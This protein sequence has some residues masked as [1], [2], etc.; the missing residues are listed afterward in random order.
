MT[1]I[2]LCRSL[3]QN[4]GVNKKISSLI[5]NH[6]GYNLNARLEML[7]QNDMNQIEYFLEQ[8]FLI[9]FELKQEIKSNIMSLKELKSFK[10][11]RHIFN[12]PVR[13]QRT[14]TNAKTRKNKK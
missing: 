4:Y 6:L 3:I 1:K 5:C 14:R 9:N 7:T 12:F 8:H 11:R 13:G 2:T 10:G